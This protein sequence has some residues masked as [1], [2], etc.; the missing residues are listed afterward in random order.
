MFSNEDREKILRLLTPYAKIILA[1]SGGLDSSVLLHIL[2][3]FNSLGQKFNLEVI[4]VN[5]NVNPNAKSWAKFCENICQ[6]FGIKCIMREVFPMQNS[7]G[8]GLE[9]TLR[10]LR[11]GIFA[12]LMSKD[13]ALVT[14]HHADD[15]AETVLLQL[16]RGAGVKG[17][18]AMA[19]KSKFAGGHLIRPLL[20]YDR[21]KLY[22]HA[23]FHDLV[24][25]DDDSNAN[26]RFD[27]N[28]LRSE[29]IPKI[30]TRWPGFT[31]T[32]SRG[33]RNCAEASYLLDQMAEKD[34]GEIIVACGII[35][36]VR[37][38]NLEVTRQKN[39]LRFW[40]HSLALPM[41]SEGRMATILDSVVNS[42][43]DAMPRV[44]WHGA[45]V[46]R[47]R[48]L[49]YAMVPLDYHDSSLVIPLVSTTV[50]LPGSLGIL[51]IEFS[52]KEKIDFSKFKIGFRHGGERINITGRSGSH[53]LVKLLQEWSVP[54]WL[55]NRIPLIYYCDTMVAVGEYYS[56][57]WL[58]IRIIK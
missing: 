30:K 2:H 43:Y 41:P 14:A 28:Y 45:E 1:Y 58:R 33:A 36:I 55:R 21:K 38:K 16:L 46:R 54:P 44:A 32:I 51:Q 57:P 49:L 5:H 6:R 50:N 17:L 27:R 31:K 4:H 9:D 42:R 23:K 37:L 8:K 56:V 53:L 20:S 35:N 3:E 7:A 18:A 25:I 24:W 12:S 34:L 26:G 10:Q 22:S 52:G 13:I 47:F 19:E 11:Y 15:Q 29:V 39:L 48:N 40:L